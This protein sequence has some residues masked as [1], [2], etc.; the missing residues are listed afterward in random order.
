MSKQVIL[1]LN[2]GSSSIK[3]A[4]YPADLECFDGDVPQILRGK[5]AGIGVSPEF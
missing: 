5:I 4:L 1:V 2:V 3:F